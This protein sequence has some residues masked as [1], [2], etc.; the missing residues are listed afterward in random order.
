MGPALPLVQEMSSIE[1]Y[2]QPGHEL[3][4]EGDALR[5]CVQLPQH[6]ELQSPA[7][8]PPSQIRRR[9]PAL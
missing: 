8:R 6:S 1:T 4:V 7:R 2:E 9:P 3:T 5:L